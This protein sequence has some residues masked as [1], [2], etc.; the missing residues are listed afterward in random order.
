MTM[1]SSS[2]IKTLIARGESDS[3][4]LIHYNTNTSN[5]T[6]LCEF[7]FNIGEKGRLCL[8][9]DKWVD[10]DDVTEDNFKNICK[11]L[12]DALKSASKGSAN[13][14]KKLQAFIS[15]N[16][17]FVTSLLKSAD[18]IVKKYSKLSTGDKKMVNLYYLAILHTINTIKYKNKSGFLSASQNIETAE[19]FEE[20]LLI[21]GW[22][23]K[24]HPISHV[25]SQGLKPYHDVCRTVKLPV[26]DSPVY[27]QQAEISIRYGILPH[28][29]IGLK[30]KN[31]FYVNPALFETMELFTR[32]TS[33]NQLKKLRNE[34]ILHGL[35]V[36]QDKF[37]EYCRLTNY[38]RYF[39][40][41]GNQYYIDKVK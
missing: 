12:S 25:D 33:I 28:F 41:C 21:I 35:R 22:V 38:Q 19:K 30:I 34:V 40:T 32:C 36:D 9:D 1:I 3:N 37:M 27:P 16:K 18:G 4:L 6:L 13:R 20:S 31:D 10:P 29:I 15:R 14:I 24:Y 39:T 11:M 26:I 5:P 8:R 2:R 23:P 17:R 7:M